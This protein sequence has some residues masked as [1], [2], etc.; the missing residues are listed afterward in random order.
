[1]FSQ[2]HG[3]LGPQRTLSR[4]LLVFCLALGVTCRMSAANSSTQESLGSSPA[5]DSYFVI[6]D[7]DGDLK[8]DLAT[9]EL[10]K[11]SSSRTARYSIRLQLTAR[12]AQVFGVTAP[13]GGLQIAAR[14]VN[15]DNALDVLVS[16]AWLHKQVAVLLNDG[17]GNFTLAEPDAFPA[18]AGQSETLWKNG[19]VAFCESA[20]LIRFEHSAGDFEGRNQFP[21]SQSRPGKARL[22]ASAGPSRLLNFSILGRAPPTIA[23]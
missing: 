3:S 4:I 20:V 21:D 16:T 22:R 12:A 23:F 8:P 5:F 13:A 2:I 18:L 6:A 1:M 17:H 19:T 7:L 15:G 14:D 10:Q 11:S 9:V